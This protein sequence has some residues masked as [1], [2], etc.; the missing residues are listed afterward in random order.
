MELGGGT[1][2]AVFCLCQKRECGVKSPH[3][4]LG[5]NPRWLSKCRRR[6][7]WTVVFDHIISPKFSRLPMFRLDLQIAHFDF[8]P[9]TTDDFIPKVQRRAGH[10]SRPDTLG[11]NQIVP[12][13]TKT[14]KLLLGSHIC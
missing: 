13:Q 5:S 7:F 6:K 9:L 14:P 11:I 3:F 10:M 2:L 12:N 8:A 4:G 1:G